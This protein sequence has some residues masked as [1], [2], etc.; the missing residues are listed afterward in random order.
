MIAFLFHYNIDQ[1]FYYGVAELLRR[2]FYSNPGRVVEKDH[3][4][5]HDFQFACKQTVW[6]G[7]LLWD[8]E[9]GYSDRLGRLL[10]Q[11]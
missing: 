10:V 11:L 1:N 6:N 7:S 2:L 5:Y 8:I 9:P 3:S 4:W